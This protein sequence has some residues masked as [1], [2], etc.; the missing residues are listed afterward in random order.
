MFRKLLCTAWVAIM[1]GGAAHAQQQK[2]G[3]GFQ[4]KVKV[5]GLAKDSMCFLANYFG[6]KQYIIDSVKADG[7]ATV[8]FQSDTLLPGGIYLFVLPDKK[9]F[10]LIM[11]RQ[12]RFSMETDQADFIEHMKITGSRD[13]EVFYEYLVFINRKAK[14]MNTLRSRYDKLADKPEERA[15]VQDEMKK[16]NEEVIAVK[17]KFIKD[18][19][20]MLMTNVFLASKDVDMPEEKPRNPDGSVDSVAVFYYYKDHFFDNVD[21]KDNRLIRTPV[22]FPKIEQY[23][24]K[25]T[26]QMPDS[27]NA[28]ADYLVEKARPSRD[29]F[30]FVVWWITNQYETSKIMGMDAVFVHMAR[31]YYTPE[32]AFWTDSSTLAKIKERAD[33]LEPILIGKHIRSMVLQDTAGNYRSLYDITAPWT[34]LVVWDPDCGHC[35]TAIPKL[36]DLYDKARKH[37]VQVYAV[38]NEAERD[39][40][41]AFIKKYDLDWINVADMDFHNNFRHE[42]DI[43][44]TPQIFLL[45]KDKKIVAKK[46]DVVT[47]SELLDEK[48]GVPL[49]L[50]RQKEDALPH[51]EEHVTSQ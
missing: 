15:G 37:G 5:A 43:K 1:L 14:E 45:D 18:H 24:K 21:F 42:L 22:L 48:L 29:I 2:H 33:V 50:E 7:N 32:Q 12:Q 4:L 27:I 44:S 30:K 41:L 39:K 49:K 9:Y 13:N 38:D 3:A 31:N 28:A 47:L 11:D 26:V 23:V 10:E 17:E 25:L 8:V 34:I 16:L 20:D 19:P 46:I 36:K 51:V 40:W 35:K 6:D